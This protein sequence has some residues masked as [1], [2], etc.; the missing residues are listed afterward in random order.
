MVEQQIRIENIVE[1]FIIKLESSA[2][3]ESK[4]CCSS[5]TVVRPLLGSRFC[6]EE[7]EALYLKGQLTRLFELFNSGY[8]ID[9]DSLDRVEDRVEDHPPESKGDDKGSDD[10][11]LTGEAKVHAESFLSKIDEV[12]EAAFGISIP[13]PQKIDR[14]RKTPIKKANGSGSGSG[15]DGETNQEDSLPI[16]KTELVFPSSDAIF[17][18]AQAAHKAMI[19]TNQIQAALQAQVHL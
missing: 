2:L 12:L 15:E 5:S 3:A 7:D 14:R 11:I 4:K 13:G 16:Y 10:A 17:Q 6:E 8:A 9:A 19:E 1:E 18:L